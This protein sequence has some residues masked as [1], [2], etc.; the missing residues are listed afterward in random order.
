MDLYYFLAKNLI[1]FDHRSVAISKRIIK[2][3]DL[4]MTACPGMKKNLKF[5]VSKKH[6][7]MAE[8]TPR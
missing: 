4:N 2:C 7:Q 5:W 6:T 3:K 8:H 1:I